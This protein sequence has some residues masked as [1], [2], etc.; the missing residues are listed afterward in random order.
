MSPEVKS[1]AVFII[2]PLLGV[3]TG[4]IADHKGRRFWPWWI[5]GYLF[6]MAALP[7]VLALSNRSR[8]YIFCPRCNE[9]I[10]FNR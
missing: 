3:I 7:T 4:L 9:Q 2:C 5:F 10:Y 8:V 1:L 6:F